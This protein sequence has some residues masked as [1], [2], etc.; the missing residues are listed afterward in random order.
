MRLYHATGGRFR[1]VT[2]RHGIR[3]IGETD[4]ELAPL[5]GDGRA[6]LIQLSASRIRVSL[7]QDGRFQV[8]FE[9]RIEHGVALAV[10]DVDGDG[11]LDIYVLRQ[12][13]AAA[14]TTSCS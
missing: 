11:D 1:D 12:R 2:S 13:I 5:D 6:D 14:T 8:V 7:K 3:S 9:R 10:G 4:A